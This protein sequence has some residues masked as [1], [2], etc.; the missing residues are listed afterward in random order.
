MKEHILLVY[1]NQ[2]DG[3]RWKQALESKDFLVSICSDSEAA[4]EEISQNSPQ[5]MLIGEH[6]GDMDALELLHL[7]GMYQPF[8]IIIFLQTENTS[9]TINALNRG[10]NDVVTEHISMEELESRIRSLMRLFWR[11]ADGY[12][13]ELKYEDIR[14]ELK[15]RK[16]YRNEQLVQLTPKE[17]ELLRYLVKRAG[18]VCQREEILQEVWGYDF[19]TGTNVVD[20]YI[21][22]LRSKIDKGQAHKLI[23]TV[24][25]QGYMIY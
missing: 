4:L 7:L 21:R 18:S 25:G 9:F 22:H 2:E 10:A 3:E 17:F 1:N 6:L 5:M 20:V 24:R 14:I 19:A 16:V 15:S 23:H 11:F 12:M 13:K 8:P